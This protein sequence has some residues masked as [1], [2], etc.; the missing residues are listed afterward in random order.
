[1]TRSSFARKS[2]ANPCVKPR[3]FDADEQRNR[4]E[5]AA[6]DARGYIQFASLVKNKFP[7]A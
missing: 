6:I 2:A 4:L 5:S 3:E 1:M 7:D